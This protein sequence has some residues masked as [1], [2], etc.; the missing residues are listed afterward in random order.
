[1]SYYNRRRKQWGGSRNRNQRDNRKQKKSKYHPLQTLAY[2][3]G[4][5]EI[6]KA[7]ANSLIFE[8]Y[9]AGMSPR[10]IQPKKTLFGG[11]AK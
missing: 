4:Q 10:E 7:N 9:Q 6:G 3:L 5:I 11:K 2:Q 1:M 8:S